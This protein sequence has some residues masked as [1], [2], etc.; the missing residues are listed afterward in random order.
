MSNGSNVS[1][2]VA[3]HPPIDWVRQQIERAGT[4]IGSVW[5]NK[6]SD[7]SLRKMCYRLHVKSP[8][9]AKIPKGVAKDMDSKVLVPNHSVTIDGHG[10]ANLHFNRR[11]IDKANNQMTVL[12]ANA[13]VRD[14]TGKVKGRGAWKT[15]PLERVTRIVNK[16]VVTIINR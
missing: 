14:E 3:N 1:E 10:R 7:N 16:G 5:F 13:V 11:L 12:D 6:R 9:V 15:I 4:T 2:I 8:S